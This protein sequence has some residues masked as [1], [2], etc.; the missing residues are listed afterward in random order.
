MFSIP[1]TFRRRAL[2]FAVLLLAAALIVWMLPAPQGEPDLPEGVQRVAIDLSAPA[3]TSAPEPLPEAPKPLTPTPPVIA[4][5]VPTL[6]L[7]SELESL[8]T[9]TLIQEPEAAPP[10]AEP[11]LAPAVPV[12]R[13]PSPANPTGGKP[14]PPAAPAAKAWQVQLGSFSDIGNARQAVDLAKNAG[15]SA[16]IV[17]IESA[18]GTAYRVRL[19]PYAD[20]VAAEVGREKARKAGYKDAG[21][22]AP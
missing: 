14:A 11:D 10:A 15:L 18:K 5:P 7:A 8:E 13:R 19:G 1:E 12:S 17:P 3:A 16:F 6:K 9:Q 22:V 4:Q 20:K 21:L 2:G